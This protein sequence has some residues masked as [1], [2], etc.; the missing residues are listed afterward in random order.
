MK[1]LITGGFGNIG[2]LVVDGCLSRGHEATIFD[3]P[4]KRNIRFSRK[5]AAKGVKVFLGNILND[6]EIK[7]AAIDQ[8][9]V[10]HLAAILPPKSEKNPELCNAVNVGGTEKLIKALQSGKS[11]PVLIEVS[12]ASVMGHTQ[13]RD[14]PVR[15]DDSLLSY[16]VYSSTKIKAELLV[17][18]SGLPFCILRLSAV[19]PTA[20]N[21]SS[22]F[23][24]IEILFDMPLDAR[25]EIVFD[26]DVAKALVAAAEN[27]TGTKEM[28]GAKGFIAGG[29]QNGCQTIVR[30]F[31]KSIFE[32]LGLPVPHE[33]LFPKDYNS[34]YLDWYDTKETQ[35]ILDYQHHSIDDWQTMIK[36]KYGFF[37]PLIPL[38]RTT[39]LKWLEKKSPRLRRKQ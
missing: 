27:M 24:M 8:D 35:D 5:Y 7:S 20:I 1:I 10:I 13:D 2:L 39:I 29:R 36:K 37:L 6:D 14:P 25:C 22:L 26:I 31:I 21:I 38:F 33:S 28:L 3:V 30:D 9:V 12:S 4:S 15:P 11:K 17:E 19:I 32:P 16:D 23:S 18:E 34:Y